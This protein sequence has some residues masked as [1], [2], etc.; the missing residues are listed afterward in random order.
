MWHDEW[1]VI[2]NHGLF[3]IHHARSD[4]TGR[5]GLWLP[6]GWRLSCDD[7]YTRIWAPPKGSLAWAGLSYTKYGNQPPNVSQA[8]TSWGYARVATFPLWMIVLLTSIL[9]ATHLRA[10]LRSRKRN[11]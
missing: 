6:K 5:E 10:I 8:Y 7:L 1:R 9:P 4:T 3:C 11:P 2:S